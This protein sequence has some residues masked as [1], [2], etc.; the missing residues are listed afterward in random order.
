MTSAIGQ[1]EEYLQNF[2]NFE[3]S[4]VPDGA[5]RDN[6]DGFDMVLVSSICL[7]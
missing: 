2:V 7:L 6:K 5:G 1:G 3:R 4:G